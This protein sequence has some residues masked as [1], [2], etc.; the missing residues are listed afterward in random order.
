VPF[1][2]SELD[3]VTVGA[4]CGVEVLAY[5]HKNY[6]ASS[7]YDCTNLYVGLAW[8]QECIAPDTKPLGYCSMY[9]PCT[10]SGIEDMGSLLLPY[11]GRAAV[12][13]AGHVQPVRRPA[14]RRGH[15]LR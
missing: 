14:H 12:H 5:Q 10:F 7:A 4:A 9:N 11:G 15:V 2:L 8:G 3:T 6:D 1:D 13:C